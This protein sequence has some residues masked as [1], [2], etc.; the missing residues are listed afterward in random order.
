MSLSPPSIDDLKWWVSFLPTAY[1]TIDHGT[2]YITMTTDASQVGWGATVDGH[3][4]QGL[5]D[6]HET[7][8]HINIL[9]LL[10]IQFGLIALLDKVHDQH[11]R[12]MS[13]NTTAISYIISMGGCQSKDCDNIARD[14]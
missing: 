2:P 7:T 3:N 14:I 6:A 10:A 5:W 13:D 12:I 1:R 8:F 9:E 4:T 11:I